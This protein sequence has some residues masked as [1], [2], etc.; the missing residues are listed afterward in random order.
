VQ[1]NGRAKHGHRDAVSS[2][3]A[4]PPAKPTWVIVLLVVVVLS[5][6]ALP[7]TIAAGISPILFVSTAVVLVLST[8]GKG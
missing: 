6:A 8:F 1:Y 5:I 7:G 4:S 2:G 3:R